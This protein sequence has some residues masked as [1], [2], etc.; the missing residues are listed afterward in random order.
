M[1]LSLDTLRTAINNLTIL[2]FFNVTGPPLHIY[3]QTMNN[4]EIVIVCLSKSLPGNPCCR[5][6]CIYIVC[7]VSFC[8]IMPA[9]SEHW[10]SA[11]ALYEG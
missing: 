4:E 2:F 5:F 1:T 3:S 10:T 11:V 9:Y 8:A 7:R 6:I